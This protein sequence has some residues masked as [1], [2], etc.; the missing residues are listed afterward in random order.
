MLSLRA[1]RYDTGE[2][3]SIRVEG[4]RISAV[5]PAWPEGDAS[6]WPFVAP[7]LFDLQ[8]NGYG[9]TWYSDQGLTPEKV[10]ET[11]PPYFACGV[12][13]LFPTLITASSE[14]LIAG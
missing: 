3:V 7:G 5:E 13:R 10:L 1:R 9:G 8:I 14:T 4:E 12:T 2:P 11:L 6:T